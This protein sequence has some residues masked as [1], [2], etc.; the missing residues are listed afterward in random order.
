V[1]WSQ[2]ALFYAPDYSWN[3]VSIDPGSTA[4]IG[5]VLTGAEREIPFTVESCGFG[6]LCLTGTPCVALSGADAALFS[7]VADPATTIQV[8]ETSTFYVRLTP[9]T[10]R[11]VSAVVSIESNDP[12]QPLFTFTITGTTTAPPAATPATGQVTSY[13]SGDD[14]DRQT[15]VQWPV[16]RFADNGDGTTTDT[17][18]GLM[19]AS[20]A[21]STTTT[22]EAAL[23]IANNSTL[24]GHDDWRLPNVNELTSLVNTEQSAP[25]SWLNGLDEFSGI[26]ANRY[27]TSTVISQNATLWG[28]VVHMDTGVLAR[29]NVS[30]IPTSYAWQVRDGGTGTVTLPKTG[31]TSLYRTG[32]D[33]DLEVGVTW[34]DPRFLSTGEGMVLDMLTGLIWKATPAG[35]T[36]SWGDALA[37]AAAL[38]TGGY[39][40]WRVPNRSELRSLVSYG[41]YNNDSYLS[42]Y[43]GSTIPGGEYWT[44]STYSPATAS[45]WVIVIETGHAQYA[46]KSTAKNVWAVRGGA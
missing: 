12:D 1:T 10:P 43:F 36:M 34:P 3:L 8:L 30:A 45:A 17:L 5:T 32:D 13:A 26:Q 40:D 29:T 25:N 37:Y 7:V 44:S 20:A 19:W 22:W 33:G 21:G 14:G 11:E 9:D 2:I 41:T 24:A 15:G 42:G 6:P 39:T 27:W 23:N 31:K 28:W 38:D 4:T 46:D 35:S 16:T 18:T